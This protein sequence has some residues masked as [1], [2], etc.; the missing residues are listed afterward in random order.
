MYFHLPLKLW[1]VCPVFWTVLLLQYLGSSNILH[2]SC[3]MRLLFFPFCSWLIRLVQQILLFLNQSCKLGCQYVFLKL[4]WNSELQNFHSLSSELFL[5]PLWP[6][7][8]DSCKISKFIFHE[9]IHCWKQLYSS[10][11]LP[12][13]VKL[14]CNWVLKYI[15]HQCHFSHLIKK[16]GIILSCSVKSFWR[17]CLFWPTLI[18]LII[19][20]SLYD[21]GMF[22][23][24]K[25][26]PRPTFSCYVVMNVC[27][28]IMNK[29]L[30]IM[31]AHHK[32]DH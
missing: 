4:G 14:L 19:S 26:L 1:A 16:L 3:S 13:I 20:L 5:F 10:W 7:L 31:L 29:M 22:R 9:K 8:H 6:L 21:G 27:L 18:T 32:A 2:Q 15:L 25:I 28:V 30:I 24:C 12:H 11:L 23:S 17:T